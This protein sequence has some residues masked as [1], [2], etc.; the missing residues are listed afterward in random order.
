M[1]LNI[2]ETFVVHAD[3]D[4]VWR[5]LTDP[6]QVVACVPGAELTST[7]DARHFHGRVKAKVGP[8]SA[9][10]AGAGVITGLDVASHTITIDASGKEVGGSGSAKV[11]MTA[12][13]A[14]GPEG[15]IVRVTATVDIVGRVMQ[16]GRGMVEMVSKQLFA[17]FVS[18]VR[19]T[20]ELAPPDTPAV[21]ASEPTA[22][23]AHTS[24]PQVKPMR[25]MRTLLRALGQRVLGWFG[26]A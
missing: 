16:F 25:P 19:A 22:A 9:S 11:H 17:D 8:V 21:E 10:Y 20:L 24:P 5:Y 3:I 2:E 18:C 14:I 1:S 13:L 6:G 4:R 26:R 7:E 12:G 15:T 23:P